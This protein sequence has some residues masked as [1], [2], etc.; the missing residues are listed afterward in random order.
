MQKQLWALTDQH[1]RKVEEMEAD[2]KQKQVQMQQLQATKAEALSAMQDMKVR[3]AALLC[4]THVWEEGGPGGDRGV[5]GGGGLP[6]QPGLPLT[7]G[8]GRHYGRGVYHTP[9]AAGSDL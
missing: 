2:L 6:G 5:G 3:G 8:G 4:G 7:E 9:A 1:N